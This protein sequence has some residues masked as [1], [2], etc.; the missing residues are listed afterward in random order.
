M[1]LFLLYLLLLKATATTFTGGTTLPVIREEFV[2][3]R[4]LITD[5]QL[6]KAVAIGRLGPGPNATYVISVGYY[7]A[8]TPGAIVG[9]LAIISPAFLAI[10]FL[11]VLQ[12]RTERP[13]WQGAIKGLT[14]AAAGLML[15]NAIPIAQDAITTT[16]GACIAAVA[17]TVLAS[18]KVDSL[19]VIGGAAIVGMIYLR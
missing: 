4:K 14:A 6:S 19:L 17:L 3:E 12:G 11:R 15:A 8:G 5:Q 18:K 7:I 9:Y 2:V 13:R 10:L 16:L 1:N